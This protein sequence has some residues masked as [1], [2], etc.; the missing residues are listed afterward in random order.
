[1]LILYIIMNMWEP[2]TVVTTM[3]HIKNIIRE[4]FLCEKRSHREFAMNGNFKIVWHWK[5]LCE[6][7]LRT[8]RRMCQC[9]EDP[10]SRPVPHICSST[11]TGT[12]S[13]Q[14]LKD[15][16]IEGKDW[17]PLCCSIS[18]HLNSLLAFSFPSSSSILSAALCINR[19]RTTHSFTEFPFRWGIMGGW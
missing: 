8:K 9:I 17:K 7:K 5:Y 6:I 1:M 3:M 12:V 18:S 11:I 16:I 19:N 14:R 4:D 15:S 13:Q 10:L 2:K